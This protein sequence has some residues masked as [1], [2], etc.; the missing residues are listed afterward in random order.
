[1]F[2]FNKIMI[3]SSRNWNRS[4]LQL[5]KPLNLF[6]TIYSNLN[7]NE[8]PLKNLKSIWILL[9]TE[10]VWLIQKMNGNEFPSIDIAPIVKNIA[11][12]TDKTIGFE[13]FP[14]WNE[15]CKNNELV[16]LRAWKPKTKDSPSLYVWCLGPFMMYFASLPKWPK[17]W[18][19][20]HPY[21]PH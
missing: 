9:F 14:R 5:W 8:Q 16:S 13:T 6:S 1:M 4:S 15:M 21:L 2:I 19:P 17:E 10:T 3:H 20:L 7:S 12:L 11:R 18:A